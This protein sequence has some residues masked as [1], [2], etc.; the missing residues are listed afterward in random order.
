MACDLDT[1]RIEQVDRPGP[2]IGRKRSDTGR[3]EFHALK[4][5]VAQIRAFRHID[6]DA[7]SHWV[8]DTRANLARHLEITLYI[9]MR[10][11]LP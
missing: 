1:H 11:D 5:E 2:Q 10:Y 8:D 6:D 7:V 4:R 3:S 9:L